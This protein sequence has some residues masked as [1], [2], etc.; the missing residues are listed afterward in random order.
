MTPDLR[1]PTQ[2]AH[3]SGRWDRSARLLARQVRRAAKH[4]AKLITLTEVA[5]GKRPSLTMPGWTKAQDVDGPGGKRFDRGECAILAEDDTWEL[6]RSRS[7]VIGPDLGPGNR[8]VVLFA[9]LRH[10]VTR[11]TLLVSVCHLPSA[12]EAVW[13]GQR[14]THYRAMVDRWRRIHATWVRAFKPDNEMVV[15]DWNL[16]VHAAWVKD[17]LAE[18]FPTLDLPANLP[19]GGTHGSR[20]I[21]MVLTRGWS[22]KR[23]TIRSARGASDHRELW[24]YGWIKGPRR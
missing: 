5:D 13:R 24:W 2:G 12:V 4:G 18:A 11:A 21:D 22:P 17:Y 16:N 14:A 23:L 10:R 7:Y 15:A 20:L 3:L 1:Y 6:V 9:L 8:V 19:K